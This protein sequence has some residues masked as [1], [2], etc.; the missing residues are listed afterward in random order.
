MSR[1]Y[2]DPKDMPKSWYNI[3]ADLPFKMDPY[4]NPA[5]MKPLQPDDMSAIFPPALIEQEISVKREIAIPTDVLD[6]LSLWRPTPLLRARNLEK[7]LGTPAKIFYKYEGTAPAGSHKANTAVAQVY[8]NKIAGIKQ[9]TTETGAG[10]WGSSVAYAAKHFGLGCTIYM[11]KVSFTQ[12]PYRSSFM[13]MFGANVIPSPSNTTQAGRDVLAVDPDTPG[14]LGTAIGEAVEAAIQNKDTNYTLGSVLNHVLLHQTVIGLE[15]QKQMESVG[16][17][18]DTVIACAGGGSNFGGIAFPFLRDKIN[19]K[20]LRAIAVEPASCPTLTKGKYTYD[21]GDTASLTPIMKMYTLGK[22]FTPP[23][24][25]AGG[26]RFHGM[27]PAVSALMKN[28]LIE[29]EIA[30]QSDIFKYGMMFAHTE[31]IV[32]APESCHAI[33]SVC[34]KALECIEKGKT[35]TILF[36]LSGNGFFDFPA[37]DAYVDGKLTDYEYSEE[38][39]AKSMANLPKVNK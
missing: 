28:G 11:V 32:P 3:M 30:H 26:L 31:G 13:R 15:A 38:D 24:I 1:I 14:S 27:S 9:L 35:E 18:P 19:G 17:Y 5:T 10:Q 34:R 4:I 16:E 37:Y 21:Y 2:L 12:K 7:A 20:E 22:D 6:M 29:A 33:S 23:A 8:Y 25:H 36:N 39:V